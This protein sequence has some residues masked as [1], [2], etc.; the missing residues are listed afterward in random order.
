MIL[1]YMIIPIEHLSKNSH[2]NINCKCDICGKEKMMTYQRYNYC[3]E[4]DNKYYCCDCMKEK[5]KRVLMEKYGVEN[6]FQLEETKDK[7][8]K[9]FMK[10]FGTEHPLK[11]DEIKKKMKNTNKERY[12]CENVFQNEEIKEKIKNKNINT[13]GVEYPMQ[14]ERIFEKSLLSGKKIKNYNNKLYYQGTYEKDFLDLCNDLNILNIIEKPRNTIEYYFNNKKCYYHPDFYIEKLNLLIEI[15][16]D[17]WWNKLKLL[18]E[19]KEKYT[20]LKGYDFL[21]IINKDY[22]DFIKLINL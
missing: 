3:I 22:H 19:T 2:V 1:R 17:Y 18:N 7:M 16:S 5:R 20:R 9:S 4:Y 12:G 13:N 6:V 21:V 14:N 8:K 11:S 10:K 15:K